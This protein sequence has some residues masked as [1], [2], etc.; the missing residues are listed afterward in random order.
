MRFTAFLRPNDHGSTYSTEVIGGLTTWMTMVYIVVVNPA[1]LAATG[2][3]QGSV[4]VAT[5]LAAALGSLL[6]AVLANYP[7]ALAPGM[8]LN[9]FF[10]YSLVLGGGYTWQTAL[11]AVFCSG[12]LFVLLSAFRLRE[13]IV[14]AIPASL[15][16]G[17]AI[18]IGLFLAVIGLQNANVIVQG[19][20]TLTDLGDVHAFPVLMTALGF[21]LILML[22]VRKKSWC[23]IGGIACVTV[24]A[25]VFDDSAALTGFAS[26]PPS[27]AP[28]FLQL[29]VQFDFSIAFS[30][31]VITLLLVD[32]FDTSGTLVA[33]GKVGKLEVNGKLER[34]RG[35]MLADSTATVVGALLG[36]ST[37]TSYIESNAGISVGGKTGFTALVASVL[38]LLTLFLFPLA[39]SIPI[40]ATAP[41]LLYVAILL[42][43]T[44]GEFTQWDDFAESAPL[45][46][47]AILIPLSFSIADGLAAGVLVY[48]LVRLLSGRVRELHPAV[49]TLAL[50]FA[51]RFAFLTA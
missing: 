47:T 39:A 40:Y 51:L 21:V 46:T 49:I 10:T 45:A 4:F 23:V 24:L 41:A 14:N 43:G 22:H 48:V 32:L 27:L 13:Y 34:L 42:V 20:G 16:I 12:V 3:D 36:T 30:T 26:L 35:A 31:A 1:M 18:G 33:I 9:A 6:M 11:M 2:M 29:D 25:W 50:V 19:T 8:G 5:C 15:K 28:T 17:S 38:F 37:T 44:L 7:I